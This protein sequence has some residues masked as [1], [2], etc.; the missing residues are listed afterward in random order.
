MMK[1]TDKAEIQEVGR[2]ARRRIDKLAGLLFQIQAQT[3]LPRVHLQKFQEQ[4]GELSDEERSWF[5]N[6]LVRRVETQ[7]EDIDEQLRRVQNANQE[8]PIEWSRVLTGLRRKM[9]S[10]RLRAFRRFLNISGG[11][12]F[13]LDFRADVLATD[14]R[15]GL[16]LEPL[17][18]ELSH[19]FNTWFQ[20]GFLFLQEITRDSPF[21]QIRF[22]KEHD[23]VHPMASLEEMGNRLGEDRRCFALYHRAMSEEPVVFI[24]GALTR[25]MTRS[26]H[27]IIGDESAEDKKSK[28]PPDTAVFYSI[29]N[30]QNG[31]AG[32]GLGKILIFQVVEAI[33]SVNPTI[34]TFCTLSPI[35]G[36]WPRYLAPILR[37]KKTNFA[38]TR[39]EL[40]KRFPERNKQDLI[41]HYVE[42]TRNEAPDFSAAL[43]QVLSNPSWIED[44]IYTKCVKEPLTELTYF[45]V[46]REKTRH[47]K[48]LNP[49]ANFHM[50]NGARVGFKNI[51]FAA[52][53]S[54]RGLS[55]SC[56]MMVN[57]VYSASWAQQIRRTMQSWLPWST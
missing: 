16:D 39:E 36:F 24:E 6:A 53:R 50:G 49:V 45:Y 33:R 4:Y 42:S 3:S 31:L 13:L 26:I 25:G 21:R 52:N 51:N 44:P 17:E 55:G 28:R 20:H 54:P 1:P 18:E 57:Y 48:P 2:S 14:R 37:G 11:F 41:A 7:K 40:E 8:D 43:F 29:N 35:P 10:P 38:L 23:M 15:T 34:K 27:A 9:E 32:L 46:T 19:L 5:F 12:K 56:G 22:L 47:G 30:T